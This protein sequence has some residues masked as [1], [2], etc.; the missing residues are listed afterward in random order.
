MNNTTPFNGSLG[1]EIATFMGL[2]MSSLD[3][4]KK[5][6]VM[7]AFLLCL[8]VID[9]IRRLYFLQLF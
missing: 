3:F 4:K 7:L 9:D 5:E 1:H 8:D 6:K 2:L